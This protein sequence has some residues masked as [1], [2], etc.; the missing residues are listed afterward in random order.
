MS[1]FRREVAENCTLL[2][3]YAASSDNFLPTFRDNLLVPFLDSCSLKMGPTG[4]PETSVKITTTHRVMTE[5]SAVL[6]CFN[7][8]NSGFVRELDENCTLLGHYAASSDN[9]YRRFGKTCRS[10]LQGARIQKRLDL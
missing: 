9:F 10:H 1:R 7:V 2:G 6:S 4:F 8:V 5:N 3:H